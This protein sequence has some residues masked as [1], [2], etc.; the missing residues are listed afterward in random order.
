MEVA[1]YQG[2]KHNKAPALPDCGRVWKSRFRQ[3]Q[4][5]PAD[6]FM[7]CP[8]TRAEFGDS[9]LVQWNFMVG[10]LGTLAIQTYKS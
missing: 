2:P 8:G 10:P 7:S 4:E 9:P 5:D 6:Q 1:A 3:G